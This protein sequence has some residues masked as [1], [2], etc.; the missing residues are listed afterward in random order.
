M[1]FSPKEVF[2]NMTA[3]CISAAM[4]Q[5]LIHP[6]DTSMLRYQVVPNEKQNLVQFGKRIISEQGI[7]KGLWKPG[8]FAG[9][10]A[11]GIGALGRVGAYPFIRD[12]I[13]RAYG[14]KEG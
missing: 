2:G 10:S 9:G 7:I 14:A 5:L 11:V 6:L 4:G 13:L 12:G 1:N 8:C 3:G